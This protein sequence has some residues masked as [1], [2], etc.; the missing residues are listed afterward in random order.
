MS[1]GSSYFATQVA[2]VAGLVVTELLH[3]GPMYAVLEARRNG[4]LGSLDPVLFAM[5]VPQAATWCLYGA[6]IDDYH[7]VL[8]SI[9]GV[10]LGVFY[11]M[12]VLQLGPTQTQC[13]RMEVFLLVQLVCIAA[14]IIMSFFNKEAALV[15]G[16]VASLATSFSLYA[17]PFLNLR[18]MV[19]NKD[20]SSINRGFLSMQILSGTM[21]SAYS[22]FE[23]DLWVLI[24]SLVCLGFGIVQL[25]L[26]LLY[27][28]PR[29]SFL[30]DETRSGLNIC[31]L[32]PCAIPLLLKDC[33]LPVRVTRSPQRGSFFEEARRAVE[34]DLGSMPGP[35]PG[36]PHPVE[37]MH[38][39]PVFATSP[40]T[41]S[42]Q[43][44]RPIVIL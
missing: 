5:T 7:Y 6:L 20:A 33:C 8:G 16:G 18:T 11:L 3:F 21:W 10:V 23:F 13:R 25:G 22:I 31:G 41:N 19:A 4:R 9:G 14:I 38:A 30:A 15:A 43:E 12:T 29:S 40:A 28:K 26:V 32:E 1:E 44:Q 36:M 37:T 2:P 27:K 34:I 17:T 35:A 42:T 39:S 24:P